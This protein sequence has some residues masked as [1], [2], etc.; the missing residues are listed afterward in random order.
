[1]VL[2]RALFTMQNNDLALVEAVVGTRGGE[3]TVHTHNGTLHLV[4]RVVDLVA[5]RFVAAIV[6]KVLEGREG[7]WWWWV[8]WAAVV[9]IQWEAVACGPLA[10]LD[11]CENSPLRNWPA[12]TSW[13][14]RPPI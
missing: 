2:A 12:S 11:A 8:T 10:G 9:V 3:S 6:G 7:G 13:C 4:R 5:I 1:M 14:R